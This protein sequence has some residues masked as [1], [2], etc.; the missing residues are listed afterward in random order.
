MKFFCAKIE[1]KWVLQDEQKKQN[2]QESQEFVNYV[3][4]LY[5]TS[6]RKL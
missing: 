1:N 2:P 5:Q 6:D 3:L 4:Q